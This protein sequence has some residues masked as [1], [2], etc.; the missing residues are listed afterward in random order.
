MKNVLLKSGLA[1]IAAF[2][3]IGGGLFVN[4]Q[5][6]DTVVPIAPAVETRTISDEFGDMRINTNFTRDGFGGQN[7]YRGDFMPHDSFLN[8]LPWVAGLGI[9][10]T[11]LGLLLIAFW[12]WM[13]VHAIRKDIDYK[14]V[15]ILVLWIM[16]I[17]GAIVYYFAVKRTYVEYEELEN[18]CVCGPDGK[19]VCGSV[20]SDDVEKIKE[21]LNN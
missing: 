13:L 2:I 7:F 12:I 18:V 21:E 16:N 10:F 17:F 5:N 14:P 3:F 9:V 15:W 19:C 4:A 1:V 6:N 11:I 8:F 20:K